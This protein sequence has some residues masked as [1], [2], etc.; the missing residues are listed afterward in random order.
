VNARTERWLA[1]ARESST[2]EAICL[3]QASQGGVV[4][5]CREHD[6]R[7]MDVMRW[8][9]EDPA[10]TFAFDLATKA[11]GAMT[12]DQLENVTRMAVAGAVDPRAAA[13][14]S[15]NYQWLAGVYDR[16]RFGE[17]MRIDHKHGLAGDHLSV[18]KKLHADSVAAIEHQPNELQR[19]PGIGGAR[20]A[21]GGLRSVPARASF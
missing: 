2:F 1:L 17:Q 14:A 8:I 6:V 9:D 20:E 5:W 15:K 21:Q 12:V 4:K 11:R 18:L 19:E 13:V 3:S 7:Y 10:R 16:R